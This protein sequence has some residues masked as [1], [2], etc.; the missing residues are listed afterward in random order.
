M[1]ISKKINIDSKTISNIINKGGSVPSEEA[2]KS[3]KKLLQLRIE[4]NLIIEI[5]NILRSDL[6]PKMSRHS[7][8]IFAIKNFLNQE[9][10]RL[11]KQQ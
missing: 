11:Q 5:D 3:A 8:I 6:Y 7:W 2:S 9:N 4:S 10:K 1:A